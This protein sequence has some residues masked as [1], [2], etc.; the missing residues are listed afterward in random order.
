VELSAFFILTLLKGPGDGPVPA[1][2]FLVRP[3]SFGA[4]GMET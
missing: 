4:D 1:I 3:H 2:I